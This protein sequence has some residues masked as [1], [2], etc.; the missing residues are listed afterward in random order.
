MG[1]P[2]KGS[3]A[4]EVKAAIS[5]KATRKMKSRQH[6]GIEIAYGD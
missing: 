5:S 4:A 3:F 6:L 1:A 2:G